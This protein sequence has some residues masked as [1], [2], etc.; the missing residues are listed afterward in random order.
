M[1]ES[2]PSR[3]F[4]TGR[5]P[6]VPPLAV[7]RRRPELAVVVAAALA[8]L[9]LVLAGHGRHPLPRPHP[10]AAAASRVAAPA[11]GTVADPVPVVEPLTFEQLSPAE[12]EA[13]NAA[14]PLA[15]R[16][17]EPARPFVFPTAGD[18]GLE[19]NRAVNCLALANYY[20]A[21]SEG[22]GGMRAISQVVLNRVRHPA[23]PKSV[24]DVVFQGSERSTGCQFTF[25]CDGSLARAPIPA[26][27]DRARAV[28]IAALHGA[29]ERG[30]GMATHYH[31]RQVVPYW[32]DSLDKIRV[33]G[34]HIF[35][36][37]RGSA[38]SRAAFQGVYGGEAT[39]VAD[40]YLPAD[41]R[42]GAPDAGAVLAAQDFRQN[43][44]QVDAEAAGGSRARRAFLVAD[45]TKGALAAEA[46]AGSEMEA[47]PL[48][49]LSSQ[50]IAPDPH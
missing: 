9:G 46:A 38:G 24:C 18:T 20:E 10:A 5:G 19:W 8:M 32:A 35:Y 37:W 50:R 48:I 2:L 44:R 45:E 27:M 25:T 30:V 28:A 40:R 17:L 1:T 15:R 26:L 3:N 7:L 29:V 31:T 33:I 13:R 16:P 14:R 11:E 41:Q 49:H 4:A 39:P 42:P 21:A 22:P 47:Q 6:L 12:A 23:F 43:A 34:A 36:V